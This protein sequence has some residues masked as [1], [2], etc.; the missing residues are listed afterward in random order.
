M[1][2]EVC[3]LVTTKA[4]AHEHI[5]ARKKHSSCFDLFADLGKYQQLLSYAYTIRMPSLS[6]STVAKL[7]KEQTQSMR[8]NAFGKFQ[9]YRVRI[10]YGPLNQIS[11]S[12]KV[13]Q[14]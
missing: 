1:Y 13:C 11:A 14:R 4:G 10:A 3:M 9:T 6:C 2:E 5:K 7:G 12:A 8:T